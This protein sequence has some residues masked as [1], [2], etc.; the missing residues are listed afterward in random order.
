MSLRS[1]E[2]IGDMLGHYFQ[3]LTHTDVGDPTGLLAAGTV[4]SIFVSL[5]TADPAV[6]GSQTASEC[7]YTGY[8]RIAVVRSSAGWTISGT[9]VDN[10]ALITFGEATAGVPETA[11]HVM[12]GSASSGAG[13]HYFSAALD[14]SLVINLNVI[15]EFAIGA[16]N[17]IPA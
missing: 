1:T 13:H 17:F 6:G 10:T 15:P 11:T 8:A 16:L 4:G 12:W 14:S 5:H 2:F 3:N 7:A 9:T